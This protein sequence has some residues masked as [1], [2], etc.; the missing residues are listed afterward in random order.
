[1]AA[2]GT[3]RRKRKAGGRD[4][5]GG[6]GGGRSGKTGTR[7]RGGWQRIARWLV[8]FFFLGSASV[9]AIA[10][11][12]AY[13]GRD[14]PTVD[15][16]RKYEPPQTTRVVDRKGRLIGEA[17]EQRRTVVAMSAVPRVLVLSVLAAEDADFYRHRGLDY[18]GI[19]RALLRDLWSGKAVQG[20]STITQQLVKNMLLTPER[21]LARKIKELILARRLETTL[22]KDQILYLYLNHIYFGH[23]RYGVQEASRFYF[24]KDVS[25][26]TLAEASLIAGLPQAPERL[27]PLKHP[28]AA[29]ARQAYVL[30]QLEAK[31]DLY[32]SDLPLDEIRA[33][34]SAGFR[35]AEPS[36]RANV[37]PEV[38]VHAREVLAAVVGAEEAARGGYT[39]ETS[40]DADLQLAA[41]RAL[42]GGLES[43][44]ERQNLR[45][46]LAVPRRRKRPER[47]PALRPGKTYD[48]VV[49]SADDA[50]G[51][52]RLDV[53]GHR[54]TA[55]LAALGRFN[56]KR[57]SA[58]AF[59]PTGAQ[60]RVAVDDVPANGSPA[61]GRIQLGPQGAVVLV[62]PRT[63][64]VL[65]LVGADEAG[66]GFDRALDAL[67]QPGSTFKPIAYALALDSKR[68]TAASLVLDAPEVYDKWRPH[69]YEAWEHKGAVRL[70]Q[71][72]AESINLVAVR[73]TKDLGPE[74]VAA[75]AR[76][77]GVTSELD[78]TLALSLG[79]SAVRPVELVNAFATFA[80]GGRWAPPRIVTRI[81]RADGTSVALP[82]PP[83]PRQVISDATAYVLTSMLRSVVTDGTGK[84]AKKLGRPVA[85]KTGTSSEARDAWFVGYTP[86]LV[87]GV[88]IG[89][90]DQRP[91]G[92]RE[93]GATTALP[94][95]LA[96]M[97]AAL[98]GKPVV[99]F[100]M[101][102]GVEIARID[103]ASGLLAP[104]GVTTAIDE[105]FVR[106]TAPT[107]VALPPDVA[108]GDSFLIE[109][110]GGSAPAPAPKAPTAPN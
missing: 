106:G 76:T 19:V 4:G 62:D 66:F 71:A 47:V 69:N 41:R 50:T 32:W 102:A 109:Q 2:E 79:A 90:D 10:V 104:E 55:A 70:R 3:N 96:A 58:S 23:G 28:E 17:F 72:L 87:G 56:P 25:R 74:A 78:P 6:S 73:V 44:D 101:P 35:L 77:L 30:G 26:L 110:F 85:G 91:L 81:R 108:S 48:A 8:V 20:A 9:L 105:V 83:A 24:E 46:P 53:G 13:Y 99:D 18:T 86:E 52:I 12:L 65:A 16:L 14:L 42:R 75:F 31:R 38:L 107:Q 21:S 89:Y 92:K 57:L 103:P 5:G 94:V 59:A 7:G 100:A 36:E 95:W 60:V 63:R 93:S 33:A 27:S 67:R 37:A 68:Y 11:V 80:A 15:S 88:W 64:E 29:R 43:I 49:T 51:A 45:G 82:A 34:R 98:D 61:R 39:I 1:M 97:R 54:V 40:I 84:E 22:D